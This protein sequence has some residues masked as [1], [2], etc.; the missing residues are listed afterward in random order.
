MW[1]QRKNKHRGRIKFYE[2]RSGASAGAG[3][4]M[5]RVELETKVREVFTITVLRRGSQQG[6]SPGWK[7]ILANLQL[8]H[9]WDT[10]LNINR[11][12][13]TVSRGFLHD[14]K[15]SHRF[16]SWFSSGEQHTGYR[17]VKAGIGQGRLCSGFLNQ[18]FNLMLQCLIFPTWYGNK[19]NSVIFRGR[20]FSQRCWIG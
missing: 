14:C 9:Y 5:W 13:N 18:F 4:W 15:T 16:V 6:P 7:R 10:M 3:E 19:E 12:I 1:R 2:R 20:R 11:R 17:E 8:R